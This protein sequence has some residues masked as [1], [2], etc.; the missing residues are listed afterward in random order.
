[1]SSEKVRSTIDS[2]LTDE[3]KKNIDAYMAGEG[4][5]SII[6]KMAVSGFTVDQLT[7]LNNALYEF[8]KETLP[9]KGQ[10]LDEHKTKIDESIKSRG[11]ADPGWWEFLLILLSYGWRGYITSSFL[12][13]QRVPWWCL[14]CWL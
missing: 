8:C 11:G 13:L 10:E 5:P 12:P 6:Q 9:E 2:M 3:D 1:L 14:W 7:E 4:D